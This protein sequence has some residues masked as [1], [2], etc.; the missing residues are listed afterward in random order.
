MSEMT[1]AEALDM[2]ENALSNLGISFNA[3]VQV[4]QLIGQVR[5]Q[6]KALRGAAAD[7]PGKKQA[8]KKQKKAAK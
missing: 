7:D 3:H 4:K 2:V 8:A 5:Q 1:A 6:E